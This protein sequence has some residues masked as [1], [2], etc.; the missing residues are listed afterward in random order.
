MA[1]DGEMTYYRCGNTYYITLPD[2][3]MMCDQCVPVKNPAGLRRDMALRGLTNSGPVRV[4][5]CGDNCMVCRVEKGASLWQ[6]TT[7]PP[8]S[9][10]ELLQVTRQVGTDPTP[11]E[12]GSMALLSQSDFQT[13]PGSTRSA[14]SGTRRSSRSS[15]DLVLLRISL[16]S[17]IQNTNRP[18][19]KPRA[20]SGR[21]GAPNPTRNFSSR[22]WPWGSSLG[23]KFTRWAQ[24]PTMSSMGGML[25]DSLYSY[26]PP[27]EQSQHV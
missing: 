7:E 12:S 2:H 25:E 24:V 4:I 5:T 21:Y 27:R 3:A 19:S 17:R 23:S 26:L 6:T 16:Q 20:S 8:R 18:V 1:S 14:K 22:T 15:F 10:E 13:R 11:T 9:L